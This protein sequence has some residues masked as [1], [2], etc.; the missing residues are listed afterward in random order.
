[1]Q[2]P[3]ASQALKVSTQAALHF[4]LGEGGGTTGFRV[5]LSKSINFPLKFLA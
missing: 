5:V 3:V 4:W 1:M 2:C